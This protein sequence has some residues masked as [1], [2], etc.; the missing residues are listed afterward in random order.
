MTS[1]TTTEGVSTLAK[2]GTQRL[3]APRS[4]TPDIKE[5]RSEARVTS[6]TGLP[7]LPPSIRCRHLIEG[8]SLG[9]PVR[10]VTL[11]SDLISLIS[12]V[13]DRGADSLW[14]PFYGS[15]LTPSVAV[16]DVLISG[17]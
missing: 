4:V 15:V 9:R 14:V 1:A 13:T 16:A 3:S 10:E 8:G 2:K 17:G 11:A 12:G 5:I 7:K 6:R